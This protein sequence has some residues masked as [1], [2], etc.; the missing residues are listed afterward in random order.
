MSAHSKAS[1]FTEGS[2]RK[3]EE[4]AGL[5][6]SRA[7]WAH[8]LG[9]HFG[10]QQAQHLA[11]GG[12]ERGSSRPQSPKWQWDLDCMSESR[13]EASQGE[14]QDLRGCQARPNTPT[15]DA[16]D[17]VDPLA[18]FTAACA[19][20]LQPL[21]DPS[22]RITRGFLSTESSVAGAA[23]V[24]AQVKTGSSGSGVVGPRFEQTRQVC[25][26]LKPVGAPR[27]DRLQGLSKKRGARRRLFFDTDDEQRAYE[28]TV[29][30][31]SSDSKSS[32]E[33]TDMHPERDSIH[34]QE[35]QAMDSSS[36]ELPERRRLWTWTS[37]CWDTLPPISG[38]VLTSTLQGLTWARNRPAVAELGPSSSKKIKSVISREG[39][40]SVTLPEVAAAGDLPQATCK[41]KVAKGKASLEHSPKVVLGSVFA[42]WGRG[43]SEAFVYPTT[44]PKIS[45]IS[46]LENP[47]SSSSLPW[48]PKQFKLSG[49]GK[50]SPARRKSQPAAA[51]DGR[52]NG[53][54]DPRAQRVGP[55]APPSPSPS[56]LCP[57]L[58]LFPPPSHYFTPPPRSAHT[59]PVC[60]GH[61]TLCA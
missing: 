7:P 9:T 12:E 20:I 14:A 16:W 3:T 26:A 5:A 45:G 27:R 15:C 35:D 29:P 31:L 36:E 25:A 49:R 32:H 18:Q 8:A 61:R 58:P 13:L 42:P 11:E 54:P 52:P 43:P 51:R 28:E 56:A 55:S 30:R 23:S 57:A 33:L 19:A 17:A 59:S 53:D 47:S 22:V 60:S 4:P 37:P 2:G 48:A 21:S 1:A 10:L 46:L 34:E 40:G 38:P 6:S 24:C 41:R 50:Q 39:G 44:F